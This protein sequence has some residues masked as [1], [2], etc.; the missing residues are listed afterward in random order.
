MERGGPRHGAWATAG[1]AR[2]TCSSPWRGRPVR[3]GDALRELGTTPE[4]L[5]EA[6]EEG[7]ASA[8]PPVE[9]LEAGSP[10]RRAAVPLLDP[11]RLD[12][13]PT[14]RVDVASST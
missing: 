10:E 14:K 13:R 1:L 6:I 11:E 2:I 8:D 4:R 5:A 3:P 12:L 9:R 7:L